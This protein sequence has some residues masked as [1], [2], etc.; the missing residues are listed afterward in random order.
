MALGRILCCFVLLLLVLVHLCAFRLALPSHESGRGNRYD[1]ARNNLLGTS[2]P[3]LQ[4][5]RQ[6]HRE[7]IE[8]YNKMEEDEV[9]AGDHFIGEVSDSDEEEGVVHDHDDNNDAESKGRMREAMEDRRGLTKTPKQIVKDDE[10]NQKVDEM[11]RSSD[12][13]FLKILQPVDFE[14]YIYM[15][16]YVCIH[17]F[18]RYALSRFIAQFY[19]ILLY[20]M[21]SPY[22]LLFLHC[23]CDALC[24]VSNTS[25][26]RVSVFLPCI[27]GWGR[28]YIS[29]FGFIY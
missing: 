23:V 2:M 8:L 20:S 13:S 27:T 3:Q 5:R 4:Q 1:G 18:F 12:T 24:L 17:P 26:P 7:Q 10:A 15:Y 25:S 6:R 11:L 14:V 9:G 29:G 19:S 21:L 28:E 16:T 22:C